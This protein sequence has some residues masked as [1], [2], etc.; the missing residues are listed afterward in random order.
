MRNI[1][2]PLLVFVVST[3][4]F[5]LLA[6]ETS[7]AQVSPNLRLFNRPELDGAAV[8]TAQIRAEI[9]HSDYETGELFS[10]GPSFSVPLMEGQLELG[11]R[12]L[13]LSAEPDEGDRENELS[14]IDLLA[15]FLPVKE[16]ELK[17][18]T[19]FLFTLPIGDDVA[20]VRESSGELD[21]ELFTA[22][23]ADLNDDVALIARAALRFNQDVEVG[24]AE[25]DGKLSLLAGLGFVFEL[26]D[27]LSVFTQLDFE[28]ERYEDADSDV[29]LSAALE[30]ALS[31]LLGLRGGLGLGLTDGAPDYELGVALVYNM[32]SPTYR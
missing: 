28:T 6:V 29:G 24:I 32:P 12:W 7:W 25:I 14:D 27:E 19:G 5:A 23:R 30:Y 3:V 16:E 9:R 1:R 18:A 15:K 26:G 17:V 2:L 4:F 20:L 10:A 8:S 22:G 11:G 21:F 31:D 13:F